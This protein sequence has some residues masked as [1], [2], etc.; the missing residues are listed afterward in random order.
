MEALIDKLRRMSEVRVLVVGDM[1]LDRFTYGTV[2]R[3]SPEAPVP[4]FQIKEQREMLG[5]AGNVVANLRT[6][7]CSVL[8]AGL[9]GRDTDGDQ[10]E[11]RLRESGA[12]SLLFRPAGYPTIVKTRLI[13][14]GSHLSRV[15]REEPLP[16]LEKI[17]PRLGRVMRRLAQQVDIVLLSD[18]GKGLLTEQTT[19]LLINICRELGKKVIVDPKGRDYAKYRGATLVKPNLKEFAQAAAASLPHPSAP[20]FEARVTELALGLIRRHDLGNLIVTLGEHGMVLISPQNNP[21]F[22]RIPTQVKEV[23]DVSGA[24][25]TSLA[26]LGAALGCDTSIDDAMRLANV[27]SGLVVAKLG[28]ATVST[29]EIA[30]ALRQTPPA[31]AAVLPPE[32]K[33]LTPEQAVPVIRDLQQAGKRVGFT[34]GVFDC[35]HLGHLRSFYATRQLCDVLVVALNTDSSVRRLKGPKRPVQDEA[36]RSQLVASLE[37]VDYVILFDDD[38]ALNLV[39]RLRPDVLAKEGYTPD[40]WPEAQFVRTYGG[41][42]VT[43]PHID[44]YSTS[45]LVQKMQ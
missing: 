30:R 23:Y 18:Y 5:G 25:D 2:E 19:P 33:I 32:R 38:T 20:E 4:V 1:M 21:P 14:S 41:Q 6:L 22:L 42:V 8:A 10:V 7:G 27:G 17:L 24:G 43:L 15:D 11:R 12:H 45:G 9:V 31:T 39:R 34:N 13:A 28:T 35:C 37:Y 36:T 44:G 29:E 40:H 16:I 3:I 26:V